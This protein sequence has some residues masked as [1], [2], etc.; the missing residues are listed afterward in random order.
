MQP[1]PQDLIDSFN[2][3][4]VVCICG[5]G[6]SIAAGFP[7]WGKLM[8]LMIEECEHQLVGFSQG[9][10]LR[11]LLKEGH[12]LE[13]ADECARLLHGQLYRDFLQ[14]LFRQDSV[15]PTK[16]HQLLTVLPF[17]ALLTTNYDNLIERAYLAGSEGNRY[18]LVY[19]HKNAAQLPKLASRDSARWSRFRDFRRRMFF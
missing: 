15:S 7:T 3:D 9:R 10:E 2:S 13:V 12:L 1:F 8:D 6:P 19:T 17:S 18:P 4:E 5:S 16:L 11:R 14:K